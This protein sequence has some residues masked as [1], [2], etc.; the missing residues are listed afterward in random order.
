MA[1]TT[2]KTW[3]VGETLTAAN[4]NTHIRD[5]LNALSHLAVR[6]SADESVTS[7][8]VL[9]NDD[10]LLLAV[11]INEVW[12]IS[13][14]ILYRSTTTADLKMAFTFPSGEVTA[15]AVA[16]VGGAATVVRFEGASP[17]AGSAVV[18]G[19]SATVSTYFEINGVFTNGGSSGNL[20][21]QWAQNVSDAAATKVM[22]N[23]TLWA[24]KLA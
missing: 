4:F 17:A 19:L 16:L 9:Q 12:Q 11:G 22:T 24:V 6:K 8:T 5:N 7:S 14:G 3:S 1:W 23:S 13:L 21:F 15:S 2:P 20:Q 10:H 18:D